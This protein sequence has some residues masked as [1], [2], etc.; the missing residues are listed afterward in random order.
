MIGTK[1][2]PAAQRIHAAKRRQISRGSREKRI[3]SPS[4]TV[5]TRQC[6]EWKSRELT[7]VRSEGLIA[8]FRPCEFLFYSD[9]GKVSKR[10]AEVFFHDFAGASGDGGFRGC[11]K[12]ADGRERGATGLARY[13][14]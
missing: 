7:S 10:G 5:P 4:R 9:V 3:P 2:T 12:F 1:N 14:G 6:G 8:F 11:L 13:D